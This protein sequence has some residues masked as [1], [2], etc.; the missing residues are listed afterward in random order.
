MNTSDSGTGVEAVEVTLSDELPEGTMKA[1]IASGLTQRELADRL[2]LKAQQRYEKE[3]Y[4]S[5]RVK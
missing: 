4:A 3:R 2:H 5:A 1:M